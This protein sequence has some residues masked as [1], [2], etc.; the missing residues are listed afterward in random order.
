[1]LV[2]VGGILACLAS[3]SL[4]FFYAVTDIRRR[5]GARDEVSLSW[6]SRH[7]VH[8][9]DAF[10]CLRSQPDGGAL[11]CDRQ[12]VIVP[13]C[14]AW[15]THA[16]GLHDDHSGFRLDLYR[17][18]SMGMRP[19]SGHLRRRRRNGTLETLCC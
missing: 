15:F 17:R 13:D 7:A 12:E 2:I 10:P 8:Y 5:T 18:A 16:H 4:T 14:L 19:I 6:R 1:M 3:I 11:Q 9:A